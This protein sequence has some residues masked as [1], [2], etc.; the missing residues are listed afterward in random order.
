MNASSALNAVKFLS[1]IV[2]LV[3]V[4]KAVEKLKHDR[5]FRAQENSESPIDNVD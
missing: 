3:S 4:I 5:G 2:T 1:K